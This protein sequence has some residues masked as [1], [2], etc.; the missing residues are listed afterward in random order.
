MICKQ[1][2][3]PRDGATGCE[4]EPVR[5]GVFW[6]YKVLQVGSIFVKE[7]DYAPTSATSCRLHCRLRSEELE[8]DTVQGKQQGS[9]G[10]FA[11]VKA[12]LYVRLFYLLIKS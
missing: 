4:Y 9:F 6:R 10:N 1:A 8:T 7:F 5:D 3:D 11:F 12:G 2:S